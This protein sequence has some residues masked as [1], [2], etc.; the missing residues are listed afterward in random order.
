MDLRSIAVDVRKED[1]GDWYDLGQFDSRLAG[2][3]VLVRSDQCDEYK[4]L[5]TALRRKHLQRLLRGE[6]V[7]PVESEN[8][9]KRVVARAALLDWRDV[10]V[11]GEPIPFSKERAK[12][13]LLNKE[14]RAF[15][16]AVAA[17]IKQVGKNEADWVEEQGKN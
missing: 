9:T 7:D 1:E 8:I 15:A 16:D 17:A 4:R 10:T 5:D 12:E 2:V 13:I 3:Q 6:T 11:D 14:F